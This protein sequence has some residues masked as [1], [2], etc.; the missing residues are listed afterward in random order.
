[1]APEPGELWQASAF[2]GAELPYA[3]VLGA[4]DQ[5]SCALE[6]FRAR[7]VALTR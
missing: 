2:K 3:E 1:V 7:L 6:F 5:R 4:E